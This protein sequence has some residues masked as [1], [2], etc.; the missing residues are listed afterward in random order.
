MLVD[1]NLII[2][3]FQHPNTVMLKL[4][5][6]VFQTTLKPQNFQTDIYEFL[7]E[8]LISLDVGCTS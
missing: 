8:I 3:I 7:Q 4:S 6:R 5:G 2:P 1:M